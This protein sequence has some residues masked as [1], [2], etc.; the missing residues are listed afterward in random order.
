MKNKKFLPRLIFF[1][2]MFAVMRIQG[3]ALVTA[4]TPKG[5]IDLEF[6]RLL[7]NFS[8]MMRQLNETQVVIN[9]LL[10]FLF[11]PAYWMFL[12]VAFDKVWLE[13][14]ATKF[15]GRNNHYA[16]I[17][18]GAGLDVVENIFMLICVLGNPTGFLV[19]ATFVLAL[20][21]FTAIGLAV[22]IFVLL[23]LIPYPFRPKTG[24]YRNKRSADDRK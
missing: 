15:Q 16:A 6:A 3:A 18:L 24:S 17:T 4:A 8:S 19:E 7:P 12:A 21:K 20:L 22:L 10:D 9:I 1:L 23:Y 5:I 11:I 13:G 14:P 2:V